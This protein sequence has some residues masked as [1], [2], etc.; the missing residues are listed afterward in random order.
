M[1]K[2]S[3]QELWV[4]NEYIFPVLFKIYEKNKMPFLIKEEDYTIIKFKKIKDIFDKSRF[5]FSSHKPDKILDILCKCQKVYHSFLKFIS[6][7][8]NLRCLQI[9]LA[10]I[11][12]GFNLFWYFN[13]K[14]STGIFL[15]YIS[16]SLH[17]NAVLSTP[18]E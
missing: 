5:D 7:I 6:L 11:K 13:I 1:Y 18:P 2:C 16:I 8:F 15:P 17:I 14:S 3:E 10:L 4:L 9:F 12:S